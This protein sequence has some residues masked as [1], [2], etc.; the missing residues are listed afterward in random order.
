M[1]IS[2]YYILKAKFD[3]VVNLIKAAKWDARGIFSEAKMP[4]PPAPDKRACRSSV[5]VCEPRA[6]RHCGSKRLFG[7]QKKENRPSDDGHGIGVFALRRRYPLPSPDKQAC[8]SSVGVCEP[9]ALRHCGENPL[10]R[11]QK[12]ENRP[13]NDGSCIGVFVLRRRYPLPSPDKRACRSSVG[14]C[15]PRALRHCGENPLLRCQKKENRPSDDGLFSLA[16]E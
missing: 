5:G 15:D 7:C 1:H 6:L 11:C 8:R 10:L 2:F 14:V 9:R 16:A 3:R 12:K 4:Q 13:S